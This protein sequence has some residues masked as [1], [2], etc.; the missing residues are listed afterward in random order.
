MLSKADYHPQWGGGHGG[1]EGEVEGRGALPN[2]MKALRSKPE[3]S[4][5]K[6]NYVSKIAA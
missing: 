3:V 2:Q 5:R 1:G 6:R 4:Q